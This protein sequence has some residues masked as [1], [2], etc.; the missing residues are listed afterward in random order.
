MATKSTARGGNGYRWATVTSTA[1]LRI[2]FDGATTPLNRTPDSLVDVN[3]LVV[4]DRVQCL[5]DSR[6]LL[7]LGAASE[8]W[9]NLSAMARFQMSGGGVRTANGGVAWS[10]RLMWINIGKDPLVNVSGYW[11]LDMPADGT[12]IQRH[13]SG[14]STVTV[15]SGIVPLV[16]WES[17]WYE[18][19][20]GA[21]NASVPGNLHI[22]AY[23]QNMTIPDNWVPVAQKNG[24]TQSF[25]WGDGVETGPWLTP[26]L[27]S[28][29]TV[30]GS[31][32]M[33]PRYKR[34][35]GIVYIEGLVRGSTTGA[36]ITGTI[37][38]LPVG[39]R[40]D[41]GNRICITHASGGVTDLRIYTSGVVSVS[42][43]LAGGTAN[44]VSLEVPPFPADQ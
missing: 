34:Q 33:P 11:Q 42:G 7:V 44:D 27:S 37:F 30:Y 14:A 4:G 36:L 18:L 16:A 3:S 40:P 1:P 13:G 17:L 9:R 10:Q 38:T 8:S 21:G 28:P 41:T 25:I 20:L 22:V 2:R 29:W 43:Y 15:A 31:G 39:Y 35:A 23:Q 5:L 26:T 24:D 19:P 12:V 6:G 32:Y